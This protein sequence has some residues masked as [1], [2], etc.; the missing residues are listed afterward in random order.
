MAVDQDKNLDK[1]VTSIEDKLGTLEAKREE[2]RHEIEVKR[3]Q[4]RELTKTLSMVR[5]LEEQL[6]HR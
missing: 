6:N 3:A 4:I 2:L 5:G 1:V